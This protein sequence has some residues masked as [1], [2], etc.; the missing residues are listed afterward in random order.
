MI[1]MARD[2]FIVACR[3]GR[4]TRPGLG[5]LA[6]AG[7]GLAG[8]ALLSG[9]REAAGPRAAGPSGA[10]TAA[11]S[12]EPGLAELADFLAI[13]NI[14]SD[15][16]NI[17]RNAERLAEMMRRRGIAVRLVE[18]AGAPPVVTGE[19]AAPGARRTLLVYAHYD[20]QPVD[21]DR[22]ASDPWTP[23]L[24][25]GRLEDG[26]EVVPLDA[27]PPGPEGDEYRLYGRGAS[28]DKG[29]IVAFLA[30]LDRLKAESVP[31]SVNV[32]LLFEG[33][34]EAGSPHL[35]E[36]LAANADLFRADGMILCDGP[37]HQ[38]RRPQIVFGARG[39]MGAELT[40]YGPNHALHSGHY[41]NW[42]PNPAAQ[43]A[44]ILASLRD[45]DGRILVPG[46]YD[47]V[48]PLDES[49]R[50]ALA[51][52]PRVEE[53]LRG[54]FDLAWSE[55]GGARLEELIMRPALNIRGLASGAVGAKAANA[56]PSEARASIDFRLV[57]DQSPERVR[58]LVEARLEALGWTVLHEAPDAATRRSTPRL[59]RLD[60]E[61]GYP[62]YRAPLDAPFSRA[63]VRTLDPATG[64]ALVVMPALGGS[65]PMELFDRVLGLPIALFPIAN[66]DNNQH[67]PNENL[68][69]RNLR[70]G[71]SMHAA[72][73]AGLGAAW[74]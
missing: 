11:V 3:N 66:H 7:L 22:W 30:A 61:G 10:E 8:L 1:N 29:T 43:L 2:P 40:V 35:E 37:V 19:I 57:A 51:G 62:A 44:G 47:D 31:L 36:I 24:R 48:R 59:L 5:R 39:V 9:C 50:E 56:V 13:P 42:A 49:D 32:K 14:A 15:E 58:E 41:G 33:E 4:I 67:A 65:I 18:A 63:L 27:L 25:A 20:G 54:E 17:R 28:D 74:D 12:A 46:Y 21:P 6:L 64:E 55:G 60:W 72:L 53:S 52:I 71:I 23:V 38:T 68:R 69:I 26:A 45:P 73:L 34:E 70:Q 16:A